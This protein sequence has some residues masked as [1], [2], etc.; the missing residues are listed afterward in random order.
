[1]L[2]KLGSE[3]S[4]FGVA[5]FNVMV[6]VMLKKSGGLFKVIVAMAFLLTVRRCRDIIVTNINRDLTE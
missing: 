2:I 3:C 5:V 4:V 6:G 1:M